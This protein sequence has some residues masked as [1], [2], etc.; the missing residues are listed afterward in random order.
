MQ[1]MIRCHRP[2]CARRAGSRRPPA[3]LA[4]RADEEGSTGPSIMTLRV[5]RRLVRAI[6]FLVSQPLPQSPDLKG[7]SPSSRHAGRSRG[8]DGLAVAL[9]ELAKAHPWHNIIVHQTEGPRAR[10]AAARGG[11][12]GIPTRRGVTVRVET[13]GTDYWA[14]RKIC[15]DPSDGGDRNDNKYID[16][17]QDLRRGDQ[18]T[19]I[20]SSSRQ[21]SDVAN[22]RRGAD[23][24]VDSWWECCARATRFCLIT[25]T[26][27]TGSTSRTPLL[28]GRRAGDDGARVGRVASGCSSWTWAPCAIPL[29]TPEDIDLAVPIQIQHNLGALSRR[30]GRGAKR[31]A[32]AGFVMSEFIIW[33][34]V[35]GHRHRS[36]VEAKVLRLLSAVV[37]LLCAPA[38]AVAE[39]PRPPS[40]WNRTAFICRPPVFASRSPT[41]RPGRRPCAPCRRIVSSPNDLAT[42]CAIFMPNPST[43]SASSSVRN[44]PMTATARS[45]SQPVRATNNASPDYKTQAGVLLSGQPLRQSTRG[46]PTTLSDYL[47]T[48]R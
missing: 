4:E 39:T 6:Y 33:P 8:E 47:G 30:Y 17:T 36:R 5:Q 48:L 35:A 32:Q 34:I 1:P 7:V 3:Q 20:G 24:R 37:P 40:L 10:P 41:T 15:A 29:A 28:R 45:S 38:L 27:R 25:S 13:D 2:C 23:R 31:K 19:S 14:G 11:V 9:G 46:D 21:R 43:A 16:N 26:R 44:R 22:A 12:K 42:R 18:D